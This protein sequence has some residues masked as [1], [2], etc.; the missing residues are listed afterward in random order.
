MLPRSNIL[1]PIKKKS[2]EMS[3]EKSQLRFG[4][5]TILLQ[6]KTQEKF[7]LNR[8]SISRSHGHWAA[9]SKMG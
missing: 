6:Q 5:K 9:E 7:L 8:L 1:L 2:Q 3:L 4:W